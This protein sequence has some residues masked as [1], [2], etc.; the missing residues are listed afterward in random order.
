MSELSTQGITGRQMNFIHWPLS[1]VVKGDSSDAFAGSTCM[2]VKLLALE[3]L[4][5]GKQ[6]R[7]ST[8]GEVLSDDTCEKPP[9][10]HMEA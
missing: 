9:E 8:E 4:R 6:G 7:C 10:G 3:K 5:G 2:E 1:P